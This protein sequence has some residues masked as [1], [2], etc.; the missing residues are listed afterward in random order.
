MGNFW[1]RKIVGIQVYELAIVLGIYLLAAIFY[2]L[3]LW[4]NALSWVEDLSRD[5]LPWNELFSLRTFMDHSGVDYL[6]KLG[7]T[8]P[9]WFVVFRLMRGA[10]YRYILLFHLIMLPVFCLTFRWLYYNIS[11]AL[12]I[13]QLAQHLIEKGSGTAYPKTI[14][15]QKGDRYITINTTDIIWIGEGLFHDHDSGGKV[16]EQLRNWLDGGKT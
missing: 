2:H 10:R 15:V 6:V 14:L 1:Q 9:I 12:D 13:E 8:I 3:T 11:E 16:S 7:L 5:T 4:I